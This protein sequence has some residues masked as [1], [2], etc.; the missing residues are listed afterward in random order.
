MKTH[1]LESLVIHPASHDESPLKHFRVE[2]DAHQRAWITFDMAGSSANVWN[3]TT[4]REFNRCLDHVAH[5]AGVRALIIRSAKE[6]VFIAGAD[7][8]SLRSGS[9]RKLEHLIDLGQSTFNRLASL[10]MPKIAL[11]HGACVGGGLELALAC[12]VRIASDSEHTRLGLPETQIGLIPAWGG[13]TRLPKLLGLPKALD[14]IITGKLL[15]P[16]E[17]K[18]VGLVAAVMPREPLE[19]A[20]VMED[21]NPARARLLDR[22]LAPFIAH[23]AKASLQAKT[24]GLYPAPL[25][26]IEVATRAP[27]TSMAKAM[28][29]EKNAIL[30]GK[31]E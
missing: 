20:I 10:P 28:K 19:R 21:V 25:R 5:H 9:T 11:I 1:L 2:V 24:R 12:D 8:K 26:A 18:R 29:L 15:K 3:D 30:G 17:A 31:G 4:L 7:L 6:R 27:F 22:L 23:R 13:S 16:S 14:L